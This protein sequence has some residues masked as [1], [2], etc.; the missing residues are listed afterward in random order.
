MKMKLWQQ[1][2]KQ[3]WLEEDGIG[4]LEVILIVAVIVI[5]AVAFRKWIISWVNKLFETSNSEL[6][7]S[8]QNSVV[9]PTP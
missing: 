7:Q 8:N 3:W 2:V 1:R 4:T 6:Q 9:V 5:I